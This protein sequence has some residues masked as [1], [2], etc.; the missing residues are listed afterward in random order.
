MAD[1]H[2]YFS[3]PAVGRLL[4]VVLAMA[5]ELFVAKAE[6]E[7][8]KTALAEKGVVTEDDLETANSGDKVQQYFLRERSE[9]AQ[10]L[11]DPA[12]HGDYALEQHWELFGTGPDPDLF[13][14][15]ETTPEKVSV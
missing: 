15:S 8:L 13:P 9:Y 2:T 6:I 10:H 7:V 1:R 4:G 3:D 5:G 12:R 14:E 11:F